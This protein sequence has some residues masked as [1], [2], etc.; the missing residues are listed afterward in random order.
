MSTPS[1]DRAAATQIIDAVV[2][3]G[4]GLLFVRDGEEDVQV[5]TRDEALEA[6]FAVDMAHLFV[7]HQDT[8]KTGWMW[9]VLGND[10]EEV[11]ADHT[12]NLSDSIDPVTDGW[13]GR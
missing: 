7:Q 6:I 11:V 13:W 1:T 5:S 4:W 8:D 12:V 3:D 10:P 9:F 2:A